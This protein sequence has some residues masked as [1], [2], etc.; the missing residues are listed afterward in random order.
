M[1]PINS[2]CGRCCISSFM[3]IFS[4][5]VLDCKAHILPISGIWL[6]LYILFI[7]I[8]TVWITCVLIQKLL[9]QNQVFEF[10][11]DSNRYLKFFKSTC[12]TLHIP[13]QLDFISTKTVPYTSGS[14][15]PTKPKIPADIIDSIPILNEI[16][17]FAPVKNIDDRIEQF[18]DDIEQRFISKW[19]KHISSDKTFPHESKVLLEGV[20][21][22]VLQVSVQIDGDKI[23]CGI[24]AILLKHLKEY[25]KAVKRASK[26]GSSVESAYR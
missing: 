12:K 20:L 2:W 11:F 4:I 16:N 18:A 21:R 6:A 8:V 13:L 14:T 1:S 15:T 9:Q 24:F 17:N 7:I 26:N 25:R 3:L 19:Y 10:D 5:F 22:R 23:L